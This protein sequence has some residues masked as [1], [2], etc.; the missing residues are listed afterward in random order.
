MTNLVVIGKQNIGRFE[1]TGI[2]GGFGEGKRAMTVKDIAE[3]HGKEVKHVNELIN[4]NIKRFHSGTDILD[5]KVVVLNDHNFAVRLTDFGFSN[6]QI[7]KSP[8]LFILSERGYAKLLKILEDDT[9]W[10]LYDQLVDSYF[11]M[12]AKLKATQP[13]KKAINTVFRQEMSMAKT[14][15]DTLDVNLGIACSVAIQR[16]EAKTGESLDEYTKLLPPAEHETGYLIPSQ[17][18]QKFN[19]SAVKVNQVLVD[20]GLQVKDGKKWRMT[21][22]GKQY[23]EVIPFTAPNGHT[24]YQL[25]WNERVLEVFGAKD[26]VVSIV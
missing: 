2:E 23:G 7:S 17:I 15:A 3:I 24:D 19:L 25:K 12:R 20:K 22:A 6:M 1:F 5:L 21:E 4:R 11:N 10:E 14:L 16:T 9:A 18:G 13:R 26:N 8:N